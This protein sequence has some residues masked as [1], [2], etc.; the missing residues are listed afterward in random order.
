M[1]KITHALMEA[2]VLVIRQ[3]LEIRL[4]AVQMVIRELI[5]NIVYL[6]I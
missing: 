1:S 6:F 3:V 2:H 4:V 5:V